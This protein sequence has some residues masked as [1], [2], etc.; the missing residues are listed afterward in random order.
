[1]KHI[2]FD[3]AIKK[4]LRDK[5]NF[6][7]LEGF[8]TELI[9]KPI[10]IES[11]LE[12]EGNQF[13]EESK[14][15]RVDIL[16]RGASGELLLIEV[17]NSPEQD[18][19]HRM[20]YGASSLITEYLSRGEAY[21]NIKKVYSINIVYFSL[22]RG[23][24]YLY[25]GRSEF[26]GRHLNDR[27]ELTPSQQE[28]FKIENI[29]QIFPEYYLLRVNKFKDTTN[30]RLDEWIY[31]LKHSEIKD[32]FIAQGL[33]EAKERLRE[34]NLPEPESAAYKR[35]IKDKQYEI[36]ILESTKAAAELVGWKKGRKAGREEG[37]QVGREE[38][39]QAGRRSEQL[40]IAKALKQEE[41]S[42]T[43]IAQVTGLTLEDIE[44]LE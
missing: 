35:Y 11:I 15:N 34:E 3:W 1:M 40:N 22:G 21:S 12:S 9:G 39:L 33:P 8:I 32:S 7:I 20:L 37:L 38:G 14:L 29:Y 44:A 31:F 26:R 4:I 5:V 24:D 17:Q 19:F 13:A 27:L 25:E 42:L 28:L 30:D 2:R 43:L 6:V 16:A 10:K 18:Y 23:E 36:S 41:M